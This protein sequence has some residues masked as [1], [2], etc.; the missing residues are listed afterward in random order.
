MSSVLSLL[1][2]GGLIAAILTFYL[3]RIGTKIDKQEAARIEECVVVIT[4][5]KAIGHL[6]DATAIAQQCGKCNGEMAKAREFYMS[7]NEKLS[8]YLVIRSAERTHAK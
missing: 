1:V 3:S 2:G 7:A 6:A 4:M 8:S 5:L